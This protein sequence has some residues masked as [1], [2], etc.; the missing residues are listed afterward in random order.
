MRLFLLK[1]V[2]FVLLVA[3]S[4]YGLFLRADGFTDPYY[5]RLT[6]PRQHS[7]I[8]GTSKAAQ[9]L[10]PEVFSERL[11][12]KIFNYSF[13]LHH[14]SYGPVY[15][16]S[17][18]KKLVENG[19]RGVFILTVD[20]WSISS[21][22]EDPEDLTT[23]PEND[24]CLGNV[25]RVD[26]D[27]NIEYLWKNKKGDFRSIIFPDRRTQ[28]HEDGWLEA[29]IDM[30]PEGVRLRTQ[31]KLKSY[32]E[33]HL[34]EYR[35]SSVRLHSLLEMVNYLK[36]RGDVYIVRLPVHPEMKS[37]EDEAMPDFD[38][39][40]GPVI[41]ES[42]G[43]LDLSGKGS[44]YVYL[45]GLHLHVDSGRRVSIDIADWIQ[46]VEGK[47]QES[48]ENNPVSQAVDIPYRK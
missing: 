15:L 9:G 20:P 12:L 18:K 43:F 37:I 5:L 42:K 16:E 45:D 36:T 10:Q 1:S 28:L 47:A 48:A 27:P 29:R 11:G 44:E 8:L 13:T 39:K 41:A 21:R 34:K 2:L 25:G 4:L 23:F 3:V 31:G 6:T 22:S 46:G 38:E 17:V 33:R 32:R 40:L 7:L 35:F 24:L 14:S 26:Q 30:S 19:D